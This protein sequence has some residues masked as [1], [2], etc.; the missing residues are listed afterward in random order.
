M[1]KAKQLTLTYKNGTVALHP[2]DFEIGKG[3][4]V[5]IV[6]PSGSGKTSLLKMM[7]GSE[8]PTGG[9]LEIFGETVSKSRQRKIQKMRRDIGPV[10]QEF[11]LIDGKSALDNVILGMRFQDLSYGKMKDRAIEALERVGLDHKLD[12]DVQY[13]SWGE[14]Q[15]VAIARAVS[16]RPALI[17]ADEPTGNLDE[18]NALNILELLSGF[19]NEETT[20]LM[21][22]HATHLLEDNRDA[23]TIRM[24]KGNL[25]MERGW[26]K[27]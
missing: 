21:A 23:L 10:F 19:R 7:I 22:T 13:L 25:L 3:E 18:D 27:P 12:S 5:Y 15:R 6:G 20:V 4:L 1:I 24:E 8:F 14:C 11:R 16:R 26:V 9:S 2:T 17:L